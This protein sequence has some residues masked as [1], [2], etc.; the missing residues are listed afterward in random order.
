MNQL[1]IAV[2][3][4]GT[5]S[6]DPQTF[7]TVITEFIQAGHTCIMVTARD[8]KDQVKLL[9]GLDIKVYYTSGVF[10]DPYMRKEH[11]LDVDIWIEDRPQGVGKTDDWLFDDNR[12]EW[13]RDCE[14]CEGRGFI[15]ETVIC[16]TCQGTGLYYPPA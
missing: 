16:D 15:S 9:K 11:D 12:K 2:D 1:L 3:Y 10:K 13:Y 4:D 7:A 5:Y 6:A 14:E 8:K